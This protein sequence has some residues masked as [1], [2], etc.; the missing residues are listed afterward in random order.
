MIFRDIT[1]LVLNRH[2]KGDIFDNEYE[3][4]NCLG[5]G[6]FG[7]VF[8]GTRISD[9]A[10]VAIK[11]VAKTQTALWT[12][13]L[14]KRVPMELRLLLTVQD[15]EGVIKLLDFA[16]RKDYFIYV[17]E[18][19]KG[20]M[21]L[22]H[23][24]RNRIYLEESQARDFFRQIVETVSDCH[25]RGVI[26]RDIKHKNI[27]VDRNMKLKLIDFGSGTLVHDDTEEFT[28]FEGTKM[29]AA[30]ECQPEDCSY[31]G[32]PSTVWTLGMLLYCMVCGDIPWHK[33]TDILSRKLVFPFPLSPELEDLIACC[34]SRSV[35]D[36]INIRDILQHPWMTP[37]PRP[38]RMTRAQLRS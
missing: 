7:D 24:L 16:E 30:P 19:P 26:H 25:D 10:S 14:G 23:F 17:M 32:G 13:L 15:V 12:R 1:N 20:C 21:D 18:R 36:R 35:Q 28:V 2:K 31:Q 11:R 27:L 38:G 22:L 5:E 34:L 4:G 29:F 6:S 9:G 3:V 8:A 37:P 33:E